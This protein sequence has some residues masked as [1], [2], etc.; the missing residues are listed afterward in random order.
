MFCNCL[1]K[2]VNFVIKLCVF[3]YL[4]AKE[5]T[6]EEIEAKKAEEPKA[7]VSVVVLIKNQENCK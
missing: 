7:K 5:E 4:K 1:L 6:V 3:M 2:N